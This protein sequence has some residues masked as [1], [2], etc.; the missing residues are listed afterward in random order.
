MTPSISGFTSGT[1]VT[2]D[3]SAAAGGD[4]P[5]ATG[6]SVDLLGAEVVQDVRLEMQKRN[7]GFRMHARLACEGELAQ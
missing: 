7:A 4:F 5:S 1:V 6:Q 3:N 2:Y